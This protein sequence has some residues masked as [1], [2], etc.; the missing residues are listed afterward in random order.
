[1]I[2]GQVWEKKTQIFKQ[3]HVSETDFSSD[4]NLK[5]G[6]GLPERQANGLR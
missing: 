3:I 4:M 2:D 1:M 5:N 6:S